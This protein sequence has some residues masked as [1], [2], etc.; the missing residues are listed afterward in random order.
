MWVLSGEPDNFSLRLSCITRPLW[1]RTVTH[2]PVGPTG[3]YIHCAPLYVDYSPTSSFDGFSHAR[4]FYFLS[5]FFYYYLEYDLIPNLIKRLWWI[6]LSVFSVGGHI[7]IW[8]L[9]YFMIL[10]YLAS[11]F[12]ILVCPKGFLLWPLIGTEKVRMRS[13]DH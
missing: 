3:L 9:L 4:E 2:R 6:W 5:I 13:S 10:F 7:W 11:L 12:R 1:L 8:S